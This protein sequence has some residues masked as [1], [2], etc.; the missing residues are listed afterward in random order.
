MSPRGKNLITQGKDLTQYEEIT[1][2]LDTRAEQPQLRQTLGGCGGSQV[3]QFGG[4]SPA[5]HLVALLAEHPWADGV[6]QTHSSASAACGL[7]CMGEMKTIS[8]AERLR[9]LSDAPPPPGEPLLR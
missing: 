6:A 9:E 7:L 4:G 8:P 3:T 1:P 5:S 2:Q